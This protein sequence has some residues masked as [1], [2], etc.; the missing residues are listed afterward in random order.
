LSFGGDDFVKLVMA[1]EAGKFDNARK[2]NREVP[3]KLDMI[4]DKMIQREK[5]HRC[6]DCDALIHDL[7]PLG[8]EN[9]S[10]GFLGGDATSAR[11]TAAP[12]AGQPTKVHMTGVAMA[13]ADIA[14]QKTEKAAD[15]RG[16]KR[17]FLQLP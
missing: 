6:A 13:S 16:E 4:I 9:A 2:L 1:K 14:P 10:L 5:Q 12:G 17:E 8:L 15:K 3:E 11:R 7:D